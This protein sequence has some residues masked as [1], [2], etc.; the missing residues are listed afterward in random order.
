MAKPA[1]SEAQFVFKGTVVRTKAATMSV[2]KGSRTAIV[3]VEEILRGPEV[4]RG[5]AGKEITVQLAPAE[6]VRG[7]QQGIF[8][9]TGWLYG[10]SLAVKSLRPHEAVAAKQA[11]VVAARLDHA[12]ELKCHSIGQ[13]AKESQLVLTGKVLAVG[14]PEAPPPAPA[15]AAAAQ[16]NVPVHQPISEHMPFW[17]EAVIDVEKVHK[18]RPDLKRVVVRFPR[19][20]DVRWYHAPK[21]QAGQE[22]VFLLQEDRISHVTLGDTARMAMAAAAPKA[23]APPTVYACLHQ[24]DFVPAHETSE[25]AAAIQAANATD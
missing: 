22:G 9:T 16:G 20:T 23:A 10:K 25:I 15:M 12:V 24:H 4:L 5:H 3:R 2:P 8:H 1:S 18:G 13:R 21:L 14:V 11:T 7:G 19:S 17:T 6:R